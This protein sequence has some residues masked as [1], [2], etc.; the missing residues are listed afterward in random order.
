MNIDITHP[1]WYELFLTLIDLCGGFD[2]VTLTA[3]E[4]AQEDF[5]F[6]EMLLVTRISA[7]LFPEE[8][9]PPLPW[10]MRDNISVCVVNEKFRIAESLKSH[11]LQGKLLTFINFI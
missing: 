8:T 6:P 7:D 3:D 11:D 2:F 1:G 4:A 9:A 10:H 5:I